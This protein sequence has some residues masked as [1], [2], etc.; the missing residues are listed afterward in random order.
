MSARIARGGPSATRR[1]PVRSAAKKRKAKSRAGFLD[2]LPISPHAFQKLT[3]WAAIVTF[4][5][6]ALATVAAFRLPQA[7]GTA[8]GERIGAAGFT[9]QQIEIRGLSRMDRAT[10]YQTVLDQPSLAMPLVDLGAIRT[11]L[12]RHTWI[13]EA[14]VSRRLPDTL[15]VDVEERRPAAV[16]QHERRLVLIDGEG[17]ALGR[18][19]LDALPNLPLIIGP[20]AERQVAALAGLLDAA[21]RLR[22]LLAGATWVGE[23]RWDLAFH[24]GETLSL[25]EGPD[26]AVAALRR[27]IAED[28][29]RQLL[30][31][32]ALRFDM[33]IDGRMIVRLREGSAVPAGPTAPAPADPRVQPGPPP[34]DPS[35]TI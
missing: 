23:R 6:L 13:R 19:R 8:L 21:P 3:I 4:A 5:V 12:L 2:G 34:A 35:Q 26:R 14:R 31:G 29:R 7:A 9:V 28:E 17:V 11:E 10:V 25:P 24:T 18:V 32:N 27:F 22:P 33:R 16:W 15:I 30:G 1:A 20:G